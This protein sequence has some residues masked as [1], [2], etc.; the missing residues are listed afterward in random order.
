MAVT[1]QVN[2]VGYD[3]IALGAHQSEISHLASHALREHWKHLLVMLILPK[4]AK[5]EFALGYIGRLCHIN[6]IQSKFEMMRA[7]LHHLGAHSQSGAYI[8]ALAKVSDLPVVDFLHLHTL[9]AVITP[10]SREWKTTWGITGGWHRGIGA[11]NNPLRLSRKLAYFC[12]DCLD[13]QRQ[14]FGF[15][16]WSRVH[17]MPG[18]YWCPWH[19]KELLCSNGLAMPRQLPSIHNAIP[20]SLGNS[21]VVQLPILHRYGEIMMEFLMNPRRHPLAELAPRLRAKAMSVGFVAGQPSSESRYLSDSVFES[22]P[23]WWLKMEFWM[24]K[25]KGFYFP[26]I[27][28]VLIGK[29]SDCRAYA[30]A[31]AILFDADQWQ[32]PANTDLEMA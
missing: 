28:D 4:P 3:Y 18:I 2:D 22:F 30:L 5:D 11:D 15:P 24:V 9:L 27:D 12:P 21:K 23:E 20:P 16:Y 17:Q 8:M 10:K 31:I 26:P 14:N 6:L 29:G 19:N 25:T 7:V 32:A 1:L 13:Q